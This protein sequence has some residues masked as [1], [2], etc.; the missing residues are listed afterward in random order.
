MNKKENLNSSHRN[1]WVLSELSLIIWLTHGRW[2]CH[3][4]L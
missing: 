1:N 4:G 3:K 2:Y